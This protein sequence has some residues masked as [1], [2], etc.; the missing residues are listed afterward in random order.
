[1]PVLHLAS[2]NAGLQ[3]AVNVRSFKV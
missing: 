3:D 1:M 2:S